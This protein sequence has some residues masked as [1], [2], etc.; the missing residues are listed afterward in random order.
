MI[1]TFSIITF[2][3]IYLSVTKVEYFGK[4]YFL[5]LCLVSL[6]GFFSISVYSTCYEYV[7]ELSPGIGESISGG[8]IN[9]IGNILGFVEINI[10]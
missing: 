5:T 6:N 3:A 10:V 9:M 2:V 7:V 8:L 1:Y 4:G